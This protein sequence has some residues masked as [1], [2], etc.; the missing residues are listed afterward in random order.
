MESKIWKKSRTIWV[1]VSTILAAVISPEVIQLIPT[2]YQT[3]VVQV[4]LAALGIGNV[5][6]R[7]DTTSPIATV[8]PK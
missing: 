2:E 4:A 5:L 8:K 7:L 1:G 6:L 3:T